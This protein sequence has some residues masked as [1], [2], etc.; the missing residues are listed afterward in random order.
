VDRERFAGMVTEVIEGQED[1]EIR[2]EEVTDLPEDGPVIIASG[3]LTSQPLARSL[4]SLTSQK[5][6]FFYDAI[7]PIVDAD[8][9]DREKVFL[10]SRYDK[11]EA[12]YINC[13]MS[14]PEYEAFY[15]ALLGAEV[16]LHADVDP[17][18]L[19]EGCL[20]IE[21]IAK[22]GR[23]GPRF[24]PMKP[25]GLK[26]PRTGEQPYAVVQLRAENRELTMYNLVGFQTSLKWDEQERVFKLIPGLENAEFLRYGQIH[27]NTYI[28]APTLLRPTYQA[29]GRDDLFFAGQITGVEGYIES[30][31]SGLL[32]GVNAVRLL[33]GEELL[34]LPKETI[35]GALAHH[36]CNADPDSFQPMNANFGILPPLETGKKRMRKAEKKAARAKISLEALDGFMQRWGIDDKSSPGGD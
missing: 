22:R 2:R 7:S 18:E 15:D 13:P 30:T 14:E 36:I 24:G 31:G 28:N 25:V 23:D 19:F 35:L 29:R 10:A 21:V 9:I 16:S 11:G 12:A 20:P 8:S 3:P 27:R 17:K 5:Y 32:A 26:D 4:F 6:L 33:K 1:I 34:V